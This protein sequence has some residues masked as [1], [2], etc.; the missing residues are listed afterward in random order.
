MSASLT[1]AWRVQAISILALLL[2]GCGGGSSGVRPDP[3]GGQVVGPSQPP[4]ETPPPA[5]PVSTSHTTVHGTSAVDL[6]DYLQDQAS[7]GPWGP[8]C[9]TWQR[10]PKMPLWMQRPTVR[11]ESEAA[12]ELHRMTAKA[13]DLINDWLP[14]E[15]RMRMGAPTAL[16]TD[17]SGDPADGV[18]HMN[19]RYER[20]GGVQHYHPIR[21]DNDPNDVPYLRAAVV[22]INPNSSWHNSIHP[23]STAG[24]EARLRGSARWEDR[25]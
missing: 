11:V 14:L 4:A 15:H 8:E 21:N 18:I 5:A 6:L 1:A 12:P 16:R 23:V 2:V 25:T 10:T 7:G 19:F 22:R 24:R 13:V 3:T 9:C 20:D 17:N